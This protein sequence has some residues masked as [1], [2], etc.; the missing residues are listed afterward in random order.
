MSRSKAA[1]R[2][3]TSLVVEADI[4]FEGASARDHRAAQNVRGR[5]VRAQDLV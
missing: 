4:Q 3:S 5:I 2:A 1:R